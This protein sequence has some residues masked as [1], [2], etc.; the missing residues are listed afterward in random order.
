MSRTRALRMADVYVVVF[1]VSKGYNSDVKRCIQ[2]GPRLSVVPHVFQVTDPRKQ[3]SNDKMG[4]LRESYLLSSGRR[5][6]PHVFLNEQK[7]LN[8]QLQRNCKGVR[9]GVSRGGGRRLG[10]GSRS[11]LCLPLQRLVLEA[12][13]HERSDGHTWNHGGA[14]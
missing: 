14:P 4:L 10:T 11:R 6:H 1:Q 3:R 9:V 12:D 8:Q 13:L 7:D 2:G 5:A